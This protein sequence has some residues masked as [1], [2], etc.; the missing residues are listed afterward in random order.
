MP[1]NSNSKSGNEESK[2]EAPRKRAKQRAPIQHRS[3]EEEDQKAH[4]YRNFRKRF[5]FIFCKDVS[6]KSSC[7]FFRG[8]FNRDPSDECL[9]TVY[10][11]NKMQISPKL[12]HNNGIIIESRESDDEEELLFDL[13]TSRGL[14]FLL[15]ASNSDLI[16]NVKNLDK[17]SFVQTTNFLHHLKIGISTERLKKMYPD[18]FENSF[19]NYVSNSPTSSL[20]KATSKKSSPLSKHK[21]TS[22]KSLVNENDLFEDFKFVQEKVYHLDD[23]KIDRPEGCSKFFIN[24]KSQHDQETK[25]LEKNHNHFESI[26]A[27]VQHINDQTNGYTQKVYLPMG[28]TPCDLANALLLMQRHFNLSNK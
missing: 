24:L 21:E 5:F 27:L 14:T 9:Y 20:S 19:D 13:L 3:N 16:L 8:K 4:S 25:F 11:L 23:Y 2:I 28:H 1:V 12:S 10:C 6:P 17:M 26:D 7:L 18:Q 15:Q 22:Q